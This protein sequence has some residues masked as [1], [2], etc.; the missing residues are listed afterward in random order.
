MSENQVPKKVKLKVPFNLVEE[1]IAFAF[2]N[3]MK[4][5]LSWATD[6]TFGDGRVIAFYLVDETAFETLSKS[7]FTK[8][9]DK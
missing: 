4:L 5:L 9:L 6:D 8:Y 3:K 2:D 7:R 1:L